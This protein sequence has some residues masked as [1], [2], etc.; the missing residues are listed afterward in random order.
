MLAIP[1]PWPGRIAPSHRTLWEPCAKPSNRP[2]VLRRCLSRELLASSHPDINTSAIHKSRIGTAGIS[3]MHVWRCWK[4][5][6]LR[7]K[8]LSFDRVVESGAPLAVWRYLEA[9][10]STELDAKE[11][12]VELPI[13][14]WP[15]VADLARQ[16]SAATDRAVQEA[17]GDNEIPAWRWEMAKPSHTPC[18]YGESETLCSWAF[19]RRLIRLC[20][21][22]SASVSAIFRLSA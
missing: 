1:R 9:I 6:T 16:L 8:F 19:P 12:R 21:W 20:K 22:S 13:K 2:R 11:L 7:G 4:I 14:N 10:G 3:V 17:C 5:W 18:G 15:T